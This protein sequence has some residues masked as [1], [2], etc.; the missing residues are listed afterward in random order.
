MPLQIIDENPEF[1]LR[2]EE[3]DEIDEIWR[4][5][6][7]VGF[8]RNRHTKKMFPKNRNKLFKKDNSLPI[9]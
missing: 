9:P 8:R 1:G 6:F 7:E 5:H 3:L 4:K 2:E